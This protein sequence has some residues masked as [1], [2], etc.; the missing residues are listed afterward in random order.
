MTKRAS[1][2][3]R[4]PISGDL[5]VYVASADYDPRDAASISSAEAFGRR[6]AQHY[7]EAVRRI[8]GCGHAYL[9]STGPEFGTRESRHLDTAQQLTWRDIETRRSFDDCIALG[10]WGAE[11]HDRATYVSTLDLPPDGEPFQ[12]P[13]GC[14]R[15]VDTIQPVRRGPH[16]RRRP[17]GRCRDQGDGHRVR[18][19]P[20]RWCDRGPLVEWGHFDPSAVRAELVAQGAT[21][22]AG[23]PP[24]GLQGF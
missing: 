7:L 23:L 18:H 5:C 15:S 1:V 20:G 16:R 12:I 24:E 9:V 21:L 3:V 14:L 19:R 22:D 10:G 8:D 2:V 17:Q 11:W 6:Q 4:L 13:L